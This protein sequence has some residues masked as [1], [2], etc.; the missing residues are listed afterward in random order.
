[1]SVQHQID[2]C[3]VAGAS[4]VVGLQTNHWFLF[5]YVVTRIGLLGWFS[6]R[7]RRSLGTAP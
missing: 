3:I 6:W 5:G 1:M 7:E 4:L 2:L